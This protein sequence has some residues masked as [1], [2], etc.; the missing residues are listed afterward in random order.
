MITD[1]DAEWPLIVLLRLR[2]E[3]L[4]VEIGIVLALTSAGAGWAAGR[5]VTG[6][7]SPAGRSAKEK[8][9]TAVGQVLLQRPSTA[10]DNLCT[11]WWRLTLSPVSASR[12]RRRSL[13]TGE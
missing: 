1:V 10:C 7:G 6:Q 4:L 8:E 5:R 3:L 11:P 9:L 2:L 13:L 12:G